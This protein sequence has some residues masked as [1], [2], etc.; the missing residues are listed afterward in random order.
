MSLFELSK[1]LEKELSG[2][3]GYK[4]SLKKVAKEAQ[5]NAKALAPRRS[6]FYK[7]SIKV[8]EVDNEVYLS[9]DDFK[10]HILEYGSAQ[11]SPQA[12]LK[13]GVMAAGLK[14]TKRNK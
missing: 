7:D 10:G 5:V 8:I 11:H 13:R 4:S 6:G 2:Q 9:T 1:N 14:F 3:N 12:P